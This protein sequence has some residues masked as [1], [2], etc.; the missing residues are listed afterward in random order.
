VDACSCAGDGYILSTPQDSTVGVPRNQALLLGGFFQPDTLVLE[1]ASGEPHPFSLRQWQIT[2]PCGGGYSAE[3]I[4]TPALEPNTTYAIRATRLLKSADPEAAKY[5]VHFGTGTELLP[6]PEL[7]RPSA[8]LTLL[9]PAQYSTSCGPL[10]ATGCLTVDD[11]TDVE[12]VVRDGS[13]ILSQFMLSN[14]NQHL[15]LS[16]LPTCIDVQRRAPT[17]RR[18]AALSFCGDALN[19]HMATESNLCGGSGA[20]PQPSPAPSDPNAPTPTPRVWTGAAGAA[21]P[22]PIPSTDPAGSSSPSGQQAGATTPLMAAVPEP[23][24]AEQ[25]SYGCGAL[26]AAP[27]GGLASAFAVLGLVFGCALRRL[28]TQQRD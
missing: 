1:N 11:P 26:P 2:G 9:V 14:N 4:P 21:S 17:G 7:T 23:P 3:L 20:S 27:G 28:A 19:V 22:A 12:V 15:G 8:Q 6:D 16:K 13:T 24:A 25:R 5:V 18:S 10:A